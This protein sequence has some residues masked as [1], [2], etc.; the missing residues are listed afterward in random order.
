MCKFCELIKNKEYVYETEYC[1]AFKDNYPVSEGHTLIITK[2]HVSN[3]FEMTELEQLDMFRLMNRIKLD[4]DKE[5]IPDGYNVGFNCGEYAGQSVMHVH[6]H[7]IPRY[8]GDVLNP[9]GGIRGVIK[10]KQNY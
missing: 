6:M 8:K 5:Y 9:R 1:I 2:R 3:L 4:L 7:I 10:E